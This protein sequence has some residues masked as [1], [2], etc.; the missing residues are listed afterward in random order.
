MRD[1]PESIAEYLLALCPLLECR[2]A[3]RARILD[4][5]VYEHLRD[6]AAAEQRRGASREEAERR[7]IEAFGRPEELDFPADRR[8]L[9]GSLAAVAAV[10]AVLLFLAFFPGESDRVALARESVD[11]VNSGQLKGLRRLLAQDTVFEEVATGRE[12]RGAGEEIRLVRGWK[13]AFPDLKGR[14]TGVFNDGDRVALEV[15]WRGTHTG[16]LSMPCGTV[17]SSG[18]RVTLRAML[19]LTIR[20]GKIK[21]TRHFFDLNALLDQIEAAQE[22]R[23]MCRPAR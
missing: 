11:V 20:D 16:R 3:R 5:E 7:A 21:A 18:S 14:I 1:P 22:A 15:T 13:T 9:L 6:I 19:V 23:A 4:E 2:G 12:V 17:T 10:L 8:R